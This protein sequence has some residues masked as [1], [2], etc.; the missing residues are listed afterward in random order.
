MI[1]LNNKKVPNVP[2]FEWLVKVGRQSVS[3]VITI[4]SLEN[5]SSVKMCQKMLHIRFTGNVSLHWS[6]KVS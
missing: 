1:I 2:L 5:I 6:S 3:H 4:F